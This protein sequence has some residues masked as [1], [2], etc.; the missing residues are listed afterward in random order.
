MTKCQTPIFL[1]RQRRDAEE[2]VNQLHEARIDAEIGEVMIGEDRPGWQVLVAINDAERARSIATVLEVQR[3]GNWENRSHEEAYWGVMEDESS[4]GDP[5][6]I[7]SAQSV[8][9][10]NLLK[11]LLADQGITAIV[12]N[13][14]LH[15]G[16][17]IDLVG[18]PTAAKVVVAAEDA[19]AA[20]EFALDFDERAQK[21]SS[22]PGEPI[23]DELTVW[24]TC[25]Q[26]GAK[27]TTRCPICET[28]G[29]D[30]TEADRGFLGELAESAQS[31]PTGSSCGCSGS[32]SSKTDGD[33][34]GSCG[35]D[36]GPSEHEIEHEEEDPETMLMCSVCDE[37]FEPTYP[38][39]CEWCDHVFEDG[40]V[41]ERIVGPEEI[42]SRAIAVAV[43]LGLL[44]LGG[45][46]YFLAIL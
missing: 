39:H 26:C 27:R 32:C 11:N 16:S 22:W 17:G 43:V 7:Y 35:A 45:L 19:A 14:L 38:K 20:R 30:F 12:A 2:L 25:P 46:I 10:A 40:Y 21:Q 4:L 36:A 29:T 37:P 33:S 41:I 3:Y 18:T 34:Q 9:Q 28:S 13:Q 15:G 23:R 8:V 1:A 6:E 24:P 5:T 44:M 42:P 31:A